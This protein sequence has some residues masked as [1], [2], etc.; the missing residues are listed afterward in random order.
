[1]SFKGNPETSDIRNS[2]S[3]D[4]IKKLKYKNIFIYDALV[5]YNLEVYKKLN[6]KIS[7]LKDGFN[8]GEIKP[9][10]YKVFQPDNIKDAFRFMSKGKHIGKIIIN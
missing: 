4:L 1:M 9:L 10:P 7:S 8:K 6:L 3:L 2:S 5:K